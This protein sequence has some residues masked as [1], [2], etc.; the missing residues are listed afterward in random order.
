MWI[1]EDALRGAMFYHLFKPRLYCSHQPI[2]YC[3]AIAC[4]L[5]PWTS[6]VIIVT[7]FVTT[8]IVMVE[9]LGEMERLL[10]LPLSNRLKGDVCRYV[11]VGFLLTRSELL[12]VSSRWVR[13]RVQIFLSVVVMFKDIMYVREKVDM[14]KVFLCFMISTLCTGFGPYCDCI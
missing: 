10:W 14:R 1:Q 9:V 2:L 12:H 11:R 8:W 6:L 4:L 5:N 13:S 7:I 3:I